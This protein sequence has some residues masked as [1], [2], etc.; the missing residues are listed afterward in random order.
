MAHHDPRT[1]VLGGTYADPAVASSRIQL[2]RALTL[3]L[4]TL[5]MPGSAQ[6][7]HGDRRIGRIAIRV[8]LASITLAVLAG[9]TFLVNRSLVFDLFTAGWVMTLGRWIL[10]V[11]AVA[12]VA[13]FADALRLSQPR[14]L[15][16]GHRVVAAGVSGVLSVATAGALFF[17]A[18]LVAVQDDFIGTV[19]TSSTVSKPHDGRYNILLLGADSGKGRDG[20]RP[21]SLN[22]VSIDADTGRAVMVGLPR[23]LEDVPFPEG[24]VMAEQF[25]SGFTCEGCMLN[26]VFTWAQDHKDLFDTDEPGLEATMDAAEAITGLKINYHAMV[27]MAGFSKLID[28]VGGVRINVRERT[29]I[30]GIGAPITGYVEAGN[31]VLTGRE[32]LWYA[33]SR[34]QNDDWS[35]MGR[36]KCVM[37]AILQQ[38]S[39]SKVLSNIQGITESGTA[40]IETDIPRQDLDVFMDLALKTRAM[41]IS[42]VSLVPPVIYTGNPD[43]R[44]VRTLVKDAIAKTDSDYRAPATMA[45]AT[46]P[47]ATYATSEKDP[48]RANQTEDLRGSC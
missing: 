8:W 37:S 30:G 13:L 41:P 10:L 25:P 14:R 23:S 40:M 36:Q 18:H 12:W 6:L 22:V 31:R 46:I 45:A 27:D 7:V 5:V 16:S 4:M 20:L 9:L 26:G 42:S 2:R 29:A 48:K 11:G 28:A 47:L 33:R 3:F 39:P 24:S 32:A 17:A 34:V 15:Q 21:D 38:L 35:R 1:S 43:Y 19:F 44:K